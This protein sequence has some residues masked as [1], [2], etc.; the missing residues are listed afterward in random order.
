MLSHTFCHIGGFG[1]K[2]ET[3]L[4]DCGIFDWDLALAAEEL[5]LKSPQR[6]SLLRQVIEESLERR[7]RSDALYFDQN[8]GASESWRLYAE[9]RHCA[10]YV[11]IE[12]TGGYRGQDHITTIA[13]WDGRVARH[14]VHGRNI[15]S[16][17]DDILS[18]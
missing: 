11:D 14:Y 5:P 17:L 3:R 12:T 18:Y 16:F 4:W 9:Y 6:R 13:L 1:V 10:A 2:T 7:A 8:L 15:E